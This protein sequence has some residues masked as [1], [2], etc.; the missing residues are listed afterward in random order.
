MLGAHTMEKFC[1]DCGGDF[2][3]FIS[4]ILTR[5][6]QIEPPVWLAE[7]LGEQGTQKQAP[8]SA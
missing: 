1:T 3:C 5:H 2:R 8:V 4:E 6:L 7:L